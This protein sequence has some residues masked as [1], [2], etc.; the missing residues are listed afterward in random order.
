MFGDALQWYMPFYFFQMLVGSA[1]DWVI[2][3][4]GFTFCYWIPFIVGIILL[5]MFRRGL[6]LIGFINLIFVGYKLLN[7]PP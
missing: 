1:I 7:P 3:G 4:N 6:F 5:L 2:S